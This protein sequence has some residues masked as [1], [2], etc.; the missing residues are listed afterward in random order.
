MKSTWFKSSQWNAVC[1]IC[2][3]NFKNT[4]LQKRWDGLMVCQ[5]DWETR[6]PQDLIRPL[7]VEQA[8]SWTRPVALE[9]FV[10]FSSSASQGCSVLGVYSNAGVGT[11]GCMLAGNFLGG[12]L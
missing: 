3:F 10:P 8:P 6:H 11:A 2:G 9:D 5:D 4:Q 12:L 7:P 1:D